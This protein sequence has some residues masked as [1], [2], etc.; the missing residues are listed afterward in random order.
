MNPKCEKDVYICLPD[1][2]KGGGEGRCGK[3]NYWLYGFRPAA[4]AWE[5]LYS[6]RLEE[7]GFTRGEASPVVFYHEGRDLA[8]VVHGDDFT[9][10]GEAEDLKWIYGEI[11]KWF[12]VKLRGIL[13]PEDGDDKEVTILGRVVTWEDWGVEGVDHASR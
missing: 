7:V 1:E 12:E 8:V 10:E 5:E 3:L 9:F 4:Q 13:G 2:A 11:Q 6:L